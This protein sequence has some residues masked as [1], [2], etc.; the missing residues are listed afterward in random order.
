MGMLQAPKGQMGDVLPF[1]RIVVSVHHIIVC[2]RFG[3]SWSHLT[4]LGNG[5]WAAMMMMMRRRRL[6]LTRQ[7]PGSMCTR[8]AFLFFWGVFSQCL[9]TGCCGVRD[10]GRR[11]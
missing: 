7:T 4:T 9:P 11:N 6:I 10:P 3:Q 5:C 1:R 8:V 2:Q